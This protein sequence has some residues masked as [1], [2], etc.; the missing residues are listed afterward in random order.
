MSL[1]EDDDPVARAFASA[2]VGPPLSTEERADLADSDPSGP[3]IPHEVVTALL[4]ERRREGDDA[5]E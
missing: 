3:W 5:A 1:P 4:A 2:I